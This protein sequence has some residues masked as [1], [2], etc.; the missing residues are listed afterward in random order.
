MPKQRGAR[1]LGF[2]TL[3]ASM[4][5]ILLAY[6]CHPDVDLLLAGNRDEFHQRPTVPPA[7]VQDHPRIW[8]GRDLEAGGTWMGRNEHGLMAGLTNRRSSDPSPTDPRSRGEIVMG[9][10]QHRDPQ[11][12]AAWVSSQ[13]HPQF[14]PYSVLFGNAQAFYSFSPRDEQ[15]PR[16]LMPGCY[17]LS[18]STLDDRTWPKVERSHAFLDAHARAPGEFL[19]DNLQRFLCDATPADQQASVLPGEEIH[20]AMGAI[21]IRSEGYGTVSSSIYTHGGRLGD[22]YCFAERADM[23]RAANEA[24]NGHR[25]HSPFRAVAME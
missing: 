10:L 18:N 23:I 20:G 19:F 8:A 14:R 6:R 4:C 7:R 22:R 5:L 3:Q 12:A 24:A 13:P 16:V 21:F 2:L 9:L 1:A 15:A 11:E 25:F 17:A